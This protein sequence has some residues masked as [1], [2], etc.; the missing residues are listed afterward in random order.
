MREIARLK[1]E[2]ENVLKALDRYAVPEEVSQEEEPVFSNE[3]EAVRWVMENSDDI[4]E[5]LGTYESVRG[6]QKDATL[7]RWQQELQGIKINPESFYRE[8]DRNLATSELKRGWLSRDGRSID[9]VAHD[10]SNYG[11]EVTPQDVVDFM[12]EHPSGKVRQRSSELDELGKRFSELATRAAGVKIGKPDSPTGRLFIENLRTSNDM[13]QLR[14]QIN[15][16]QRA[17]E[18]VLRSMAEQR[19]AEKERVNDDIKPVGQGFFGNIYDQF[20]GR[21]K[22]AIDFLM[23]RKEGE[24]IGALHHPQVGDIDLVWGNDKAGLMKIAKKHPEMLDDLQGKVDNMEVISS[25]D[26]RIILESP[27][28]RAVVS[29][30]VFDEEGKQWL[31][32]A[33]EK[34]NADISG[35]SIDIEPEPEG[36]QNG[37]APL[38]NESVSFTAK[39]TESLEE[40]QETISDTEKIRKAEREVELHPTEAQQEAGNYKKGHVRIDGYDITIENPKGSERSGTDVNGKPWS[41]VINNTYGYIRGTKGVDG[42]HIDVFL[43]DSPDSGNVYVVDQIKE[44]GS[45]D[46][47]KVMFGFLSIEDAKS[48]YLSNYSPGWKGLGAITEV[49]KDEFKKWIDSSKRKTKP[50]YEYKNVK[51]ADTQIDSPLFREVNGNTEEDAIFSF[52][53]KYGFDENDVKKYSQSMRQGNLG[54]ASYAFTNMRRKVR[55]DNSDKSLGEFTKIFAPIK[56]ELYEKFGNIDALREEQVQ[57]SME[58]R[59]VMEAARKRAEEKAEA[60]RKRL[61][62]FEMMSDEQLDN[63]YF[64]AIENNDEGR[65]R[66]LVNESA[67]KRGYV[68]SDEFRMAHRAPSYDEEGYDKSMVDVAN[69]KDDIRESLNEQLRMNRDRNR[70]ESAKAIG[71]ALSAIDRGEKPTITIYR[72]VPKSLK[73]GKVRNGDWVTL[74]ESYAKQHGNHA[75][76]GDYRIM[77]EEVPAENLY[78]DGNDINEWGYDDRSDYRYRNT[79]NNRKLNDLITRDDN[80]N[81][82]PLSKRFNARNS[83][84]R[85]RFIGEK[86][87]VNLDKAEEATTRLDNLNVAR[88]MEKSGKDAKAIKLAT[89]WERGADGKWRYETEDLEILPPIDLQPWYDEFVSLRNRIGFLSENEQKRFD[90]LTEMSKDFREPFLYGTI[91]LDKY[92]KDK[93]LFKTYPE[94]KN[95]KLVFDTFPEEDFVGAYNESSNRIYIN[96]RHK[97]LDKSSIIS[98]EIQHAIQNIE[99]FARGGNESTYRKHLDSLQEK[100][101]AWSMLGEFSRK[102]DELGEDASQ[103]DVY[104]ALRDEYLSDGFEFGDGFIPSRAAF[105]KGFNLWVRG[106]DKEGYEDAYNEYQYFAGKYGF[107]LDNNKYRELSG[108]VEASNVQSRLNMTPEERRN[109]LASETEDVVRED[110]IFLNDALGVSAS[111]ESNGIEDVNRRFNEELD[112]FEKGEQKGDLHLGLPGDVLLASGLNNTEIYITPKTLK[113][114]FGKHG[115]NVDD[116]KDLP[117]ALNNPL[118]VYE[119]GDKAKSLVVITNIEH[120]K[121]RITA[122]IK[123]ERNGNRLEVNELASIHPKDNRRFINDMTNAKRGGLKEALRYVSDKKKALDWLGLVPPK[124]TASLTKQELDIANVIK[125]FGNPTLLE[126]EI[127]SAIDGLSDELGVPVNRV[128][129]RKDL[130]EGI[131]RQMKNGRYPGLFDPKTG[132]VYMVMD[133]ITNVADAQATMLHEIVGHKGIR[134]LFEDKI[135]EF[136]S[137]FLD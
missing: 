30:N 86:G 39:D 133:E 22:D 58:E 113:E 132:E 66:D 80:G 8:G 111:M 118:L 136:T 124:G 54:G 49:S 51:T 78:W 27:T 45:F 109:S 60:E 16:A 117:S 43:S 12:L 76:E 100:R 47:H 62:E 102:R 2:R 40:N 122:A 31:L 120:D 90:E 33:Y 3:E 37:T 41:I 110:Q 38:Q 72:A 115:L 52:S 128:K 88:E 81:V 127:P 87:A 59:N 99:G 18:E 69:N 108:E 119:W 131:Q 4:N 5:V 1:G 70:D 13:K 82:I 20:R 73:E 32:T 11:M 34:K 103:I 67:H 50:F 17:E 24:A 114:H 64:K 19:E 7:P 91:Y 63:E 36:K 112:A 94:L 137:H 26:N 121:G 71:K 125:D 104:N 53:Q 83:D 134:G 74:S 89:G 25:S 95:L 28:D 29:K 85:F 21:A 15:D 77:S 57:R 42:D 93:N 44:D 116:I 6:L 84:P 97:Y 92:V 14:N 56:N 130:P 65:M 101:D 105:D 48:A 68:S 46:E 126:G 135:G 98:H 35:S 123:L 61:E 23:N 96:L 79:R 107:G 106:Y 10:L 9:E 129:S 75:L 55:L